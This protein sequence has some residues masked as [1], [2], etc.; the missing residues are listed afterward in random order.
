MFDLIQRIKHKNTARRGS[1]SQVT[2]L[3][4]LDNSSHTK[5]SEYLKF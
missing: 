3:I 4:K 5:F 2:H 1:N